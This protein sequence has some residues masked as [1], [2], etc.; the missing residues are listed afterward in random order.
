MRVFRKRKSVGNYGEGNA[1]HLPD[2]VYQMGAEA[3][4]RYAASAAQGQDSYDVNGFIEEPTI[5]GIPYNPVA[6]DEN[7]PNEELEE[8][9]NDVRRSSPLQFLAS[10]L[11]VGRPKS[12]H[13]RREASNERFGRRGSPANFHRR[14]IG[15]PAHFNERPYSPVMVRS[16]PSSPYQFVPVERPSSPYNFRP[17]KR[18]SSPHNFIPKVHSTP[19]DV[20]RRLQ[21]A[22]LSQDLQ[23]IE[24]QQRFQQDMI[25]ANPVGLPPQ[26]HL[27]QLPYYSMNGY[28]NIQHHPMMQQGPMYSYY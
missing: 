4:A 23:N 12:R 1:E 25:M 2:I 14:A 27:P 26:Y 28:P 16:R 21:R 6:I 17:E 10:A 15:S 8:I 11:G 13:R 5:Y 18:A 24:K 19:A 22:Q 9:N 3:A 7:Y 20:A